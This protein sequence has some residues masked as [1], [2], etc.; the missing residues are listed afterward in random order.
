MD[1]KPLKP[2]SPKQQAFVDSYLVC[3]NATQ[4]AIEA[5]YSEKTARFIGSENLTKPN[6]AAALAERSKAAAET[7]DVDAAWILIRL[8]RN[9]ERAAQA[10]PVTDKEG[11]PTGEYRYD[12]AV[13][14]KALELLGKH[15]NIFAEVGS[16]E[17]PL[18]V[19]ADLSVVLTHETRL[20]RIAELARQEAAVVFAPEADTGRNG[21]AGPGIAQ[22]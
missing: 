5:G 3:R 6:I 19:K 20:A 16:K 1:G 10:V 8:K 21:H 7:A 22:A 15:V 18:H 9:A 14:N 17:N 13:V 2:L 12:G 11:T 4:A